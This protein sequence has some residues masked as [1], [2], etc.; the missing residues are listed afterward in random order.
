MISSTALG[1]RI[2]STRKR[3]GLTQAELARRLELSRTTLVAVEKGERRMSDGELIRCA[4]ILAVS[5]HELLRP[6]WV[7]G[8]IAPR[9]RLPRLEEVD[10]GELQGVVEVLRQLACKLVTLEQL[11]DIRRPPSQIEAIGTFHAFGTAAGLDPRLA[12]ES[13]AQMVRAHLGLGDGPAVA[14]DELFEVEAGLKIFYLEELP[15]SV[16]GLLIW[17]SEIGANVAIQPRLPRELRRWA[18]AHELGRCLFDPEAGDVLPARGRERK[19]TADVFAASFAKAF[20]LPG[21]GVSRQFADRCRSNVGRFTVAD[22]V[23]MAG[24]FEVPLREMA[25]RLEEL[26][27]VARGIYE[28]L[29]ARAAPAKTAGMGEAKAGS[30]EP[31]PPRLPAR[32]VA[33]ACDA[34]ELELI[35]ERELVD[36]L[37]TDRV[38]ARGVYQTRRLRDLGE[39]VEVELELAR[40]VLRAA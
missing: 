39:G 8:A 13:A 23:R 7:E 12:A 27:L 3:S 40:S 35:S 28:G 17:G 24:L 32:Y 33:L 21:P 11:L 19:Q 34:F 9:F 18:L 29:A 37:E 10:R 15:P 4:E 36:Y 2:A 31:P 16:A 38:S 25:L 20:L 14:L 5:L 26:G 30:G 6:G 22:V 1:G